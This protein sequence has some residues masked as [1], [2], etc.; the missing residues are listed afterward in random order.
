[1][2]ARVSFFLAALLF[3]LV[4]ALS[5]AESSRYTP[6][7]FPSYLKPP[8]S[9][10]D[11]MPFARAA[12]RQTGG[13]TPLGLVEKGMATLIV[14]EVRADPMVMQAIKR[15]YEERGVKVYLASEHELL[16]VN[17]E[18]AIKAIGATQW[19]TSEQGYMEIRHWL[20]DLFIEPE[21]PKK[22]LKERRPDLFN[23]VYAKVEEVPQKQRE[24][25]KQFVITK[26]CGAGAFIPCG[27]AIPWLARRRGFGQLHQ[28]FHAEASWRIDRKRRATGGTFSSCGHLCSIDS[29]GNSAPALQVICL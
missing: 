16:G 28:A 13:R 24:L 14:A 21:V 3:G 12:V 5:G 7:R 29:N 17:K 6:P 20:D 2:L 8:K 1:M 15:A 26:P 10:D 18:E 4:S 19:Y 9:I 25:A 22:W 11:V 23:A 27:R